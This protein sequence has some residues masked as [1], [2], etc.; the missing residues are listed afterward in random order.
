V[1]LSAAAQPFAP[2]LPAVWPE[3]AQRSLASPSLLP[4]IAHAAGGPFHLLHPQTFA[5]NLGAFQAAAARTG[6]TVYFAKKANKAA[7]WLTICAE[8]GAGV[9]VA[10]VPELR[11][12]LRCGVSGQRVVVTGPAKSDELLLL[13]WRSDALIA[14]DSLDE[15]ERALALTDDEAA[16]R[17]LL[18][19]HPPRQPNSRFGMTVPERQA[20]LARIG[21][22]GSRI[23]LEGFSFHLSGYDVADRAELAGEL[24]AE[25]LAARAR[26]HRANTISIGGGFP[27]RYVAAEDW[28]KFQSAFRPEQCH[29]RKTFP[30]SFYPY[31][32]DEPG[33]QALEKILAH[34]ADGCALEQRL[35][36]AGIALS[37]E[38]GRALLADAGISVFPVQGFK[39]REAAPNE[40]AGGY[41][42]AT[43]AGTSLS[44]SE[45]WFGSEF[46]PD[47]ALWP[48][49]QHRQI[50]PTSVGGASCLDS[51]MLTWRKVPLPRPPKRGDFLVYPNTAGYQ[52]DSNE[53]SFHDLPIPPKAVLD[54]SGPEPRWSL[55]E[56]P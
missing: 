50:T 45:Q 39:W 20:A 47:P 9:D 17:V 46:L 2:A 40:H 11:E 22:F 12:A 37:V 28:A 10:S 44:L 55:E 43:V 42:I 25:C 32:C 30:D 6:G 15:L 36:E 5:A 33:A 26:G 3:W 13:A 53:S 35:G 18:R 54:L 8:R 21:Q 23:L 27:V 49:T 51:D 52:M 48:T 24:V 56:K 7:A 31:H 16:L 34:Q 1:V 38:P 4:E 29:A 14:I 41:G 19:V